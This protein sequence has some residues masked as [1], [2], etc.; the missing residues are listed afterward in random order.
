MTKF[1]LEKCVVH[2][3]GRLILLYANNSNKMTDLIDDYTLTL[4][5]SVIES[6]LR[7][8]AMKYSV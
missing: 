5:A 1:D 7:T 3:L 8:V 2:S 4:K 6:M